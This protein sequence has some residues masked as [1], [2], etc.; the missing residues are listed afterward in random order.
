VQLI[1]QKEHHHLD[2]GIL[3]EEKQQDMDPIKEN[4]P[5]EPIKEMIVNYLHHTEAVFKHSSK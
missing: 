5:G 4:Q 3:V 2:N 1:H